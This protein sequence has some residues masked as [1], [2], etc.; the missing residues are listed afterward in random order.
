M[1]DPAGAL[2]HATCFG[3]AVEPEVLAQLTAL[4]WTIRKPAGANIQYAGEPLYA[5]YLLVEGFARVS[6]TAGN[7][8]ELVISFSGAGHHFNFGAMLDGGPCTVNIDAVTDVTILM[9]PADELLQLAECRPPLLRAI[10]RAVARQ[11]RHALELLENVAL[12]PLAARL[13]CLLLHDAAHYARGR[14]QYT[15][16]QAEIAARLGTVREVVART[17]RDFVQRGLIRIDQ[18]RI[19]IL[20]AARLA[21]ERDR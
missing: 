6:R 15:A 5:V 17:L 10:A 16:N 4:C 21:Q 8:R 7:G 1:I 9:L 3:D 18:H 13:A 14:P 11:E 2:T 20:D 12:H 19:E